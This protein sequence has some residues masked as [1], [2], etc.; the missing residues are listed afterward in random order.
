MMIKDLNVLTS[1]KE[2][3]L[4]IGNRFVDQNGW[5][6]GLCT[7]QRWSFWLDWA[8]ELGAYYQLSAPCFPDTHHAALFHLIGFSLHTQRPPYNVIQSVASSDNWDGGLKKYPYDLNCC[9]VCRRTQSSTS[10]GT[11]CCNKNICSCSLFLSKHGEKRSWFSF[12]FWTCM[13]WFME[14]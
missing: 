1:R 10:R 4:L 8:C 7:F 13:L 11:N 6:W 9:G 14:R 2:I 5:C 12:W 3:M